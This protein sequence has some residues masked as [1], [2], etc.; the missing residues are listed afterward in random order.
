[1]KTIDK[2]E[3]IARAKGEK[4]LVIQFSATWCGPC[5]ALTKTIESNE[6]KFENPIYKMDIDE[7]QKLASI[8]QIRSVPTLIRFENEQE[9]KRLVGAQTFEQ[10][11]ELTL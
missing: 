11:A 8:L 7:N 5:K 9:V 4:V 10:L 1:M 3:F 2:N 6:G